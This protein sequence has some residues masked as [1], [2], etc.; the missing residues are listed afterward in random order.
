MSHHLSIAVDGAGAWPDLLSSQALLNIRLARW[1]RLALLEPLQVGDEPEV[2]IL[3]ELL[4]GTRLFC[5]VPWPQ[6]YH[7][8]QTLAKQ[9]G[10]P[11]HMGSGKE[12]R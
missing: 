1:Q 5:H 7:A 4:D 8:V 3:G 12:E 10:V 2:G 6:L 11:E 9:Y